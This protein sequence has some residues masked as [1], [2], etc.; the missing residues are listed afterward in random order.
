MITGE[1]WLNKQHQEM[2]TDRHSIPQVVHITSKSKSELKLLK[3]AN[4]IEEENPGYRVLLYDDDDM[5]DM[6]AER[7]PEYLDMYDEMGTIVE[8]ADVWRYAVMYLEGGTYI[9]SDV[10]IIKQL[11]RWG[12]Y[13]KE[14][15]TALV[16]AE[17]YMPDAT[18]RLE[19]GF[20]HPVQWCQWTFA[21]APQQPLF[22]KTLDSILEFTRLERQNLIHNPLWGN[23]AIIE[24]TGP[25]RFTKVI[26]EVLGERNKTSEDMIKEPYQVVDGVAYLPPEAFGHRF[27]IDPDLGDWDPVLV[28]HNFAGS[29]KGW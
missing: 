19:Q 11:G 22:K 10:D 2:L 3:K 28:K 29:W 24:R 13:V 4:S 17:I 21:A 25:G 12:D 26:M 6:I 20:T 18:K 27:G 15:F 1:R 8:R 7:L 23:M 9:D 14:P 5:R 16:G